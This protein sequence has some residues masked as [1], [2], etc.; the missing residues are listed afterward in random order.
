MRKRERERIHAM[1][2]ITYLI[3]NSAWLQLDHFILTNHDYMDDATALHAVM[4]VNY[5]DKLYDA[6]ASL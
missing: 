4:F 1:E 6:V 3:T 2:I 5:P